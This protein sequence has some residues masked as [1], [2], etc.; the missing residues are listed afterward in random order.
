MYDEISSELL[1][2]INNNCFQ[3]RVQ[4]C[5]LNIPNVKGSIK[6]IIDVS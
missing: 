6:N 5:V 2:S 3:V 4:C 1:Q